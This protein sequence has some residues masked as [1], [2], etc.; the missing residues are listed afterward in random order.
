MS[1][2]NDIDPTNVDDLISKA[3]EVLVGLD[4][5]SD[6]HAKALSA[7]ERLYK[8]RLSLVPAPIPIEVVEVV[9]DKDRVRFKDWLPIIATLAG[10][11]I[12]VGAE[13]FG[14]TLTSK[15]W[16]ERKALK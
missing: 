9:A 1:N 10:T 4:A 6:E 5:G 2:P 7:L 8:I 11:I 12:I 3:E 14:H 16:Q 15:A 13:A